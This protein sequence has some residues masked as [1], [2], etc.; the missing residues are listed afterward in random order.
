MCQLQQL[1]LLLIRLRR[2]S[3]EN[4]TYVVGYRGVITA[5]LKV[6]LAHI[7]CSRLMAHPSG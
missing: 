6:Q 5:F 4:F 1:A 7:L 2:D 3:W